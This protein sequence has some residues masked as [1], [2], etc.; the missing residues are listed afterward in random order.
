MKSTF[1]NKLGVS[2]KIILGFA[3]IIFFSFASGIASY[4]TLQS[5]KQVD[6]LLTSDYYPLITTLKEYDGLIKDTKNLSINWMYL[7]NQ[8][9]KDDLRY[10][11]NEGYPLLK[12]KLLQHKE[13]LIG[14]DESVDSLSKL[15]NVYESTINSQDKLT[16]QLNSEEAYED[17]L[18][19]FDLMPLLNDD[20]IKPLEDLQSQNQEAINFYEK[21]SAQLLT[22]KHNNFSN[23]ENVIIFMTLAGILSGIILA[24]LIAK[25][26]KR[27]L[28]GE[29]SEVASIANQI[30]KGNLK[31]AFGDKQY[32]GIYNSMKLMANKLE[33][34]VRQVYEEANSIN[35]ASS[36]MAITSQQVSTGA[37]EQAA[38]TEEVSA[39]M[40]QMV[41]NIQQNSQ[42]A[43]T[44]E[45]ISH[46]AMENASNGRMAVDETVES[47]EIIADKVSIIKEIARQTNILAL[48]A[49]VE[50]ARANEAGKGFAVVA[51]EVRR[52]AISSQES[53]SEIDEL[54][55]KSVVV[56]KNA[57]QLIGEL[58]PII[59]ETVDI[60]GNINSSSIEQKTGAEQVNNAIQQLNSITQ[61]SSANAEEMA[62]NADELSNQSNRLKSI[63]SFFQI[64]I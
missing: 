44:G 25:S 18:L 62:A 17:D 33:V 42:S 55:Q 29:P 13:D 57:G 6:E 4:T 20:I 51:A 14:F 21:K 58:I 1:W 39:S 43:Q 54:C 41:A 3:V 12:S 38:S 56:A 10:I 22:D 28:G 47:M 31:I 40:E 60:V 46:T 7:P 64:R 30:A 52:L 59:N 8:K 36:H 34:I 23:V 37:S 45:R 15:I 26:I 50:A 35:Q 2:G 53:A 63:I 32:T 48:N 16:S 49:A 27:P 19:L 61:Q 24:Y 11:Q 5:S 9:N